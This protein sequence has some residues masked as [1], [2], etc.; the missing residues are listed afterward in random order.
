MPASI[1]M[2]ALFARLSGAAG[3][4]E[5]RQLSGSIQE[6]G[7]GAA[8][9][10]WQ[11]CLD[12]GT[13]YLTKYTD[14]FQTHSEAE[15]LATI[16]GYVRSFGAWSADDVA[17]WL[18]AECFAFL[19]QDIAAAVREWDDLP[20][21]GGPDDFWAEYEAAAVAGRVSGRLGLA[22]DGESVI[23]TIDE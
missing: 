3:E 10:T 17:G 2:T 1:T 4:D 18:P 22:D 9:R 12:R 16:R 5:A 21:L 6:M 19:L 20:T 8:D 7:P 23:Y 11:R 13:D 14:A 15:L